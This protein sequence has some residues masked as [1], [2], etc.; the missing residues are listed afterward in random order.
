M[1]CPPGLMTE[2]NSFTASP[3]LSRCVWVPELPG[4]ST[5]SAINRSAR[6][7]VICPVM[8]TDFTDGEISG[9]AKPTSNRFWVFLCPSF[10]FSSARKGRSIIIRR[11]NTA[12]ASALSLDAETIRTL[13]CGSFQSFQTA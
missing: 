7:P 2:S 12:F 1:I 8:P 6:E 5:S 3:S 10:V 11:T 9:I 13:I 4:T